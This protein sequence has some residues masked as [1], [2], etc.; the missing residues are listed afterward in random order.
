MKIIDSKRTYCPKC[1]RVRVWSKIE[2]IPT[3]YEGKIKETFWSCPCG[4]MENKVSEGV[5]Q[6]Q[7]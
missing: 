7:T 5:W 1:K 6:K 2:T 4:H 3:I